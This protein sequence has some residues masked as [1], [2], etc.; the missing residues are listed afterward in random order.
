MEEEL[1]GTVLEGKYQLV[2]KLG[3][4]GMGAVYLGQHVILEKRVAVKF[5]HADYALDQSIVQR[6]FREAQAAA[7]I[8]HKNIIDVMDV[9]VTSEGVPYLV[10]EYLEGESLAALITRRQTVDLAAAC[11]IMEPVLLALEAAHG[12]GIVHRDLKPDNIFLAHDDGGVPLVKLI[13]FGISKQTQGAGDTNLTQ[14]GAVMGTPCYMSP[15]QASGCADL[16]ARSDLWSAGVILHELLAGVPPFD[17]DNINMILAAV[18]TKEVPSPTTRFPS[19][20]REAEPVVMRALCRDRDGR[21][22]SATEM[23]QALRSTKSFAQRHESLTLAAVGMERDVASGDL[24]TPPPMPRASVASDI[25]K[26]MAVRGTLKSGEHGESATTAPGAHRTQ[27]AWS[28]SQGSKAAVQGRR[29]WP[30]AVGFAA[31][32]AIILAIAVRLLALSPEAAAPAGLVSTAPAAE[33]PS[34][35]SAMPAPTIARIDLRGVPDGSTIMFGDSLQTS[36]VFTVARG[37]APVML[38]V[39]H[40][41]YLPYRTEITPS[42]DLALEVAMRPDTKTPAASPRPESGRRSAPSTPVAAKDPKKPPEPTSPPDAPPAEPPSTA[43]PPPTH[44]SK[45][46]GRGTKYVTDFE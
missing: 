2:R 45:E 17:G 10:M 5:L 15:E 43:K 3:S 23:L 7:A 14:A 4:G 35:A 11:G 30:W 25:F 9:A 36:N 8:G 40:S 27:Q 6:F 26:K 31:L 18:L 12:R 1:T 41:G 33:A 32:S 29:R 21:F 16:D 19:F 22:G 39:E 37:D 24:G 34:S 28:D 46:G 42:E 13:D 20:P 38:S 44:G